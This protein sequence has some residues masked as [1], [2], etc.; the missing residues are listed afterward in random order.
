MSACISGRPPATCHARRT[1]A[2]SSLPKGQDVCRVRWAGEEGRGVR[3]SFCRVINPGT[4]GRGPPKRHSP[5][6]AA[7]SASQ[8]PGPRRGLQRPLL[9]ARSRR[10]EC[11]NRVCPRAQCLEQPGQRHR[12]DEVCSL[13]G[14]VEPQSPTCSRDCASRSE[15]VLLPVAEPRAHAAS[16]HAPGLS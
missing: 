8:K 7:R 5:Q 2:G 16:A 9:E 10:T 11:E 12:W 13:T 1:L 6:Q 4:A 3:N 15:L 14:R